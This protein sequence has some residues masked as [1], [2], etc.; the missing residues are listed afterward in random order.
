MALVCAEI[1]L[2]P[3]FGT[4]MVFVAILFGVLL[5][6]GVQLRWLLVLALV[7]VLGTVGCSSSTC[8]ASTRRSA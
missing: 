6:S 8:C 1:L 3:D 5:V 2:L 4:F 7:G